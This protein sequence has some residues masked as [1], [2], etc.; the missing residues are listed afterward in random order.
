MELIESSRRHSEEGN[1]AVRSTWNANN[2]ARR[3]LV[4]AAWFKGREK[5]FGERETFPDTAE[6]ANLSDIGSFFFVQY[7]NFFHIDSGFNYCHV[8]CETNMKLLLMIHWVGLGRRFF[9]AAIC[10][11]LLV[12]CAIYNISITTAESRFNRKFWS[13][14][15]V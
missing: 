4:T 14:C 3:L 6:R 9:S 15:E 7:I 8:V 13:M 2:D 10:S 12:F 5:G 1:E 11:V